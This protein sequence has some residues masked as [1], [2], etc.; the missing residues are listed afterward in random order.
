MKIAKN[1]KLC[2]KAIS[3][4]LT[5][6]LIIGVCVVPSNVGAQTTNYKFQK[7]YTFNS[8]EGTLFG[9]ATMSDSG[10]A[11]HRI[12]GLHF[13]RKTVE[14]EEYLK[15]FNLDQ[16][17]EVTY[18]SFLLNDS[19]GLFE[20]MP[21]SEYTVSLKVMVKY[22]HSYFTSAD[23]TYPLGNQKSKLSLV[24]GM[25]LAPAQSSTMA[26]KTVGIVAK[27]GTDTN[28]FV[29]EQNGS[30]ANFA[31]G[32]WQTL[33]YKFTTP[34]KFGT[35]GSE[36]G[37]AFESYNGVEIYID[38]IRVD[39]TCYITVNPG[40]GTISKTRY[41][42]KIGD[43]I[44]IET[45]TYQFG[46]DFAGWYT[47]S[48]FTN[49]FTDTVVTKENCNI[50]L[51]AKF[52]DTDFSFES[53]KPVNSTYSFN[54]P[55]L[56]VLETSEA[57]EGKKVVQ[58]KYVP[59]TYNKLY[60]EG[61]TDGSEIPWYNRRVQG[62]NNITIK[63][64]KA[65]TTYVVTFKCMIPSGMGG[66]TT[67]METSSSTYWTSGCRVE[68]SNTKR[69]IYAGTDWQE[70]RM[71]FT[72]GAL[73][74]SSGSA[75]DVAFLQFYASAHADTI[76]YIDDLKIYEAGNDMFVE[77][78]ANGGQF[79]DGSTL[80]KS[81]IIFE[82]NI[83]ELA[84]PSK[85][86]FDFAGWYLEPSCITPAN[87]YADSNVCLSTIYAK[88][89]KVM[90]FESYAYS[91]EMGSEKYFSTNA[92]IV[93]DNVYK[94]TKTL[95]ITN[96]ASNEQNFVLL[97][98]VANK[99]RYIV[100]FNYKVESA[101]TDIEV[102][103]ATMN[104]DKDNAND[105]TV[106]P[107]VHT[108]KASSADGNY[109]IGAVV[110][111]T[112]IK[113]I[114]A[115]NLAL[116]V[117]GVSAADYT[118]YIDEISAEVLEDGYGFVLINDTSYENGV[119][120]GEIGTKVSIDGPTKEAVKFLGYYTDAAKT[121]LYNGS[122]T[123][124]ESGQ[125]LYA[126]WAIGNNFDNYDGSVS[127]IKKITNSGNVYL[128]FVANASINIGNVTPGKK[129]GV[130][131]I[132]NIDE[133][134][135]NDITVTVAGSTQTKK[136][137]LAGGQWFDTTF[138][139][140]PNTNTLSLSV[141]L[142]EGRVNIDNVVIYEITDKIGIIRF[143]EK[144][145]RGEDSVRAGAIGTSIS[146]PEKFAFGTDVFVGWCSNSALT[147]PFISKTFTAGGET[148]VYAR[149]VPQADKSYNFDDISSF[150]GYSVS[151]KTSIATATKHSGVNSILMKKEKYNYTAL[152]FPLLDKN[153]LCTL[154]NNA[155]YI[156]TFCYHYIGSLTRKVGIVASSTTYN[157]SSS[158]KYASISVEP[159]SDWKKYTVTFTTN[160]SSNNILY[161]TNDE[162]GSSIGDW[163]RK[164]YEMYIDTVEIHRV[165]TNVNYTY[166]F[167]QV[168][169]K[170]NLYIGQYGAEIAVPSVS[171]KYNVA[172][173]VYLDQAF[174]SETSFVHK[175]ESMTQ[176]YLHQTMKK[177]E[178]DDYEYAETNSRYARGDDV[179]VSN[180][181]AFE[182]AHSLKYNY[183]YSP[184]YELSTK[185]VAALGHV[186]NN[187]TYKITF[188]Y[189]ITKG[190]GDVDIKFR[191][192]HKHNYFGL[193]TEYKEAQYRIYGGE[194]GAGW[195]KATV[196]LKT[197]FA[198]AGT[199]ALFM[200]FNPVV[201]G[202]TVIFIDSVLA[203]PVSANK[204]VAAFLD[205]DGAAG[206]YVVV[207]KGSNV[208]LP[209]AAPKA[210]F[211][212]FVGWYAD[213]AC[214]VPYKGNS[215]ANT[216][217]TKLYSKWTPYSQ[218]FDNY[219]YESVNTNQ[220][221]PSTNIVNGEMVYTSTGEQGY[222]RLGKIEDNTSYKV[223]FHYKS[224]T[225]GIDIG[226]ITADESNVYLNRTEYNDEGNHRI[227]TGNAD[228]SY[229]TGI[230]YFTSSFTYTVPDDNNVNLKENEN[231]KF[232]DMLYISIEG[233]EGISI[234][235]T[236][237]TVEKID[238]LSNKGSQVLT[239]AAAESAGEQAL[240]VGYG[241]KATDYVNV[242][243]GNDTLTLVERGIIF[244]NAKNTATGTKTDNGILVSPV[245][246]MNAGNKG[247]VTISK[248]YGFNEFWGYDEKTDETVFSGYITNFN[249][250][251]SRLMA[252]RGYIKVKDQWGNIYTLYSSDKKTSIKEN[253]DVNSEI[254]N[255][256]VHTI[257]NGHWNTYT[258]VHPKTMSYIYGQQIEFLIDY[259]KNT[260]N[261]TLPR[262][263]E[264]AATVNNEILIG[265]TKRA[266]SKQIE[267]SDEDKYVITVVGGKLIIKGG[268]DIATM[269]AVK[270]FISYL[271]RKDELGC[272][273]D[274]YE[275][276]CL[277][278]KVSYDDDNFHLT[279]NDDFDANQVNAQI[280]QDKDGRKMGAWNGRDT[281][282]GGKTDFRNPGDPGYTTYL[283]RVVDNGI[284][285]RNGSAILT[286]AR[287]NE[288]QNGVVT[289]GGINNIASEMSTQRTMSFKYGMW[290]IKA[291]LSAPV[292]YT[293][294]WTVG[295]NN[296]KNFGI[297]DAQSYKTEIDLIENF[298]VNNYFVPNIH[299][300]WTAFNGSDPGHSSLDSGDYNRKYNYTPDADETSLYD[301]YHTFTY[302]WT[303]EGAVFAF[304]GI[305][306]FEY[307]DL[308][309]NQNVTTDILIISQCICAVDMGD[310]SWTEATDAQRAVDYYETALDYVR[311]YQIPSMGSEM[312]YAVNIK[313]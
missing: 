78:D 159:E 239:E 286:A 170:N 255:V 150:T 214:T 185:N 55:F 99:E 232:G 192:A 177:Q 60:H 184:N 48:A 105:L 234:A 294:F 62:D 39:K 59:E 152:Y 251:D 284:F 223:T 182:T 125:S 299:Y 254:T 183:S 248:T 76:A 190:Q 169:N 221:S 238:V 8:G 259:A 12:S 21:S 291:K 156:V 87:E 224:S 25:P 243:V 11:N 274:L 171:S 264:K 258:I 20:L 240:R 277:E 131:F 133:T 29:A 297:R 267:I 140:T 98:S 311:I 246:L 229:R 68:Y 186:S 216:G 306:Y 41:E 22:P 67:F 176:L 208:P 71:V 27:V 63:K 74:N 139:V 80:K 115:D 210:Q 43:P 138:V 209:E 273:A 154:E 90:G 276:F 36:L 23:Q 135:L 38:E 181:D 188:R 37:L 10:G 235:F 300:W 293:G 290:E 14:E 153:G 149:W 141:A 304:D 266:E 250:Q 199:G 310:K 237:F 118:I 205:N 69:T 201:E 204:C 106:Y 57:Y 194:V 120:I 275:G 272:G 212:S 7:T 81:N 279:F 298:G 144:D 215:L 137:S 307:T 64:L 200:S 148:T 163:G 206:K 292:S 86:G 164:E 202:E 84:R 187:T 245:T 109:H 167:D 75:A 136:A 174:T 31:V 122:Y 230:L 285:V 161:I 303:E 172:D 104:K 207:N 287:V 114:D 281:M 54:T 95:K 271:K 113:N 40:V 5:L 257:A 227:V 220:Y 9:E 226:F 13:S 103:F 280:W 117:K 66:C 178:F 72:T 166:I 119:I 97:N 32:E 263:T 34:N 17:V 268:S 16:S 282:L 260:H 228:G 219:A 211:A 107:A 46:Y 121:T 155:T 222:F 52:S 24:Y 256:D 130:E 189:K 283:G 61:Y 45:P 132:F 35:N 151:S 92:K 312:N 247:H 134:T 108:V 1:T 198:A 241:Y 175:N 102:G 242:K 165:D 305:K 296:A 77:L 58:Y 3:A 96:K 73:K 19:E 160:S 126:E 197:K 203:E 18:D 191:T 308:P 91:T 231:A 145:D 44:D 53:Y 253:E 2:M 4:L 262:V 218:K 116:V 313:K 15:V 82:Q 265:D 28:N 6:V 101:A 147:T 70:V 100:S 244:K 111:E 180:E 269:Q 195:K 127:G 158:T 252:A 233:A 179:T 88:W 288:G 301:D 295:A 278:G 110:I 89:S 225:P 162:S 79:E 129:Y 94:G 26:D 143:D 157:S 289:E 123:F 51:Y 50:T 261:V 85:E 124:G 146:Y 49:K 112:D 270:D 193:F 30:E 93:T 217:L 42:V 142:S 47:D 65:N 128:G 302:L 56:S 236:D 249:K 83:N 168:G 309:Y 213:E 33:T 196:Y 173:G